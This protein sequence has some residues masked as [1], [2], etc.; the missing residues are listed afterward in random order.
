MKNAMPHKEYSRLSNRIAADLDTSKTYTFC[1]W[2]WSRFG[3]VVNWAAHNAVPHRP[4]P[5]SW[6]LY[7]WPVHVVCY[8]LNDS[9]S[10]E[11]RGKQQ[12]RESCK[13]YVFDAMFCSKRSEN[14]PALAANIAP[15]YEFQ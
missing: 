7:D 1:Y 4:L 9:H 13:R 10:N 11:K 14:Y 12:H 3:D 5:L 2:G 15:R 8:E 6:M